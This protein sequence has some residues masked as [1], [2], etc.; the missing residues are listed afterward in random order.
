[1][2]E[3][4]IFAV[5]L[6]P[7]RIGVE[8]SESTGLASVFRAEV[9]KA[10]QRRDGYVVPIK[11]AEA[12]VQFAVEKKVD[13]L[14]WVDNG[15]IVITNAASR[16]GHRLNVYSGLLAVVDKGCKMASLPESILI[17]KTRNWTGKKEG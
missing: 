14:G 15:S 4:S 3:K 17:E 7:L 2:S 8:I 9:F 13:I 12:I 1:M 11:A 10:S 6:P 16:L 5:T